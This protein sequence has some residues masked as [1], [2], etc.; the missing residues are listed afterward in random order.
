MV[1]A[2]TEENQKGC[3]KSVEK[4]G[5]VLC[6]ETDEICDINCKKLKVME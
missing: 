4:M 6:S 1:R 2:M 5:M 3:L